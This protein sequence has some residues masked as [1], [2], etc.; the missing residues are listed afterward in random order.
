MGRCSLRR[1]QL[2][3]IILMVGKTDKTLDAS[4]ALNVLGASAPKGSVGSVIAV[5]GV[6]PPKG[7]DSKVDEVVAKRNVKKALA[8]VT[9][10]GCGNR[11]HQYFLGA[12]VQIASVHWRSSNR[13][14]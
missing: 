2:V 5:V 7:P 10:Q 8:E 12:G 11:Q 14:S 3:I 6:N 13:S 9:G 1:R 4:A